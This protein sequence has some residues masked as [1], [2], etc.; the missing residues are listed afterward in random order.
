MTWDLTW[1][2]ATSFAGIVLEGGD[3]ARGVLVSPGAYRVRLNAFS[4]SGVA[5]SEAMLTVRRDP[6]LVSVTDADL[7]A[8]SELALRIR[9]AESA[10]NEA[11]LD[12]RRRRDSWRAQ[13]GAAVAD[14]STF[15]RSISRIEAELY[16][17]R[18]QSAKDKIAFPIKLNDRLTGLRAIVEAGEGRP[19]E[20]QYRVFRDLR[21]E[22]DAL[23]RG[24]RKLV[25]EQRVVLDDGAE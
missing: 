14:T 12:I 23:L 4:A 25:G 6:R 11:V 15:I 8:Q 5:R 24:L 21:G 13:H 3:P 9:D 16:Q 17:V 22:L 7:R 10:A 1:P 19:T 20:A 2:G 18:N